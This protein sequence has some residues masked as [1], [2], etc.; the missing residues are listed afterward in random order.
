MFGGRYNSNFSVIAFYFS[1]FFCFNPLFGG[2]YNSNKGEYAIN[3]FRKLCFNPL[4]GGRYNSNNLLFFVASLLTLVSILCLVE[5][6]IQILFM[7]L[8]L[9]KIP[10]VSILC[11]V[12]DTIQIFLTQFYASGCSCVSILCLVEDTIQMPVLVVASAVAFVFQ[13]F[14]WW[15]IQFK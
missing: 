8:K 13:S 2:R 11:L 6:T 12:E 9:K 14:V 5:D 3:T 7:T 15:K 1:S 4:F 10:F